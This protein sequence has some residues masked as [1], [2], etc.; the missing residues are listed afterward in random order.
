MLGSERGAKVADL[1][2][3]VLPMHPVKFSPLLP[4]QGPKNRMIEQSGAVAIPFFGLGDNGIHHA[5]FLGE[6]R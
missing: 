3:V 1:F 2:Y 6:L 5:N 4:S